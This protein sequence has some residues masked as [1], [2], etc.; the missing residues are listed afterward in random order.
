[1]KSKIFS[2]LFALVLALTLGI[3]ALPMAGSEA[4][5]GVTWYVDGALGTDD[6][7]HGTG[8]GAAAFKTIQY[9]INDSRVVAGST[10]NVAAGTYDPFTVVGKADLTI[11]SSSVVTVQGLQIPE[12]V[13]VQHFSGI[14]TL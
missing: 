7:T 4:N 14:L 10:I 13:K 11:Q 9:A 5:G 6:N 3:A 1:M 12:S 8:S 2:I